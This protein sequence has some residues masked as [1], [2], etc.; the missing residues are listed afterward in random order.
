MSVQSASRTYPAPLLARSTTVRRL[1][2]FAVAGLGLL[3][4]APL[5]MIIAAAI[6]LESGRPIFFSQPRLGRGGRRFSIH[7]FRKFGPACGEGSPVTVEND[8]RLTRVGHVLARTK[9]DELPQLWNILTGDMS[10]VGPRPE[11]PAFADCFVNGF[12]QVLD[13]TPGLLGPCQVIFRHEGRLYPQDVDPALFYRQILF[14]LKARIDIDYYGR[15]TFADDLAWGIRAFAA[16]FGFSRERERTLLLGLLDQTC[17]DCAGEG[18]A[19]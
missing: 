8:A 15:R 5:M 10:L 14:P 17:R 18:G 19:S 3:L 7:K 9:L 13:H 4:F 12:E 2:D 6:W 11:S 1:F 16:V